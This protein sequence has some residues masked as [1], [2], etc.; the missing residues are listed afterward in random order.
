[1]VDVEIQHVKMTDQI[2]RRG[3]AGPRETLPLPGG[4]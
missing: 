1:M 4:R 3:K 2:A